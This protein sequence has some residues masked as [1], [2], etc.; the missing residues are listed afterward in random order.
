MKIEGD[1]NKGSILIADFHATRLAMR[2]QSMP[3]RRFDPA[4]WA[5][6]ALRSE[7]GQLML[8][9]SLE[10]LPGKAFTVGRLFLEPDPPG[11][12]VWV[13]ASGVSDRLIELVYQTR[14][15]SRVLRDEILPT[16]GDQ[17][18]DGS[19]HWSIF[20]LSCTLPTGWSLKSQRLNAGDLTLS[21][22]KRNAVV[23]VRQIA[24]A[25]LALAR[26]PLEKWLDAQQRLWK[27]LYRPD[28]EVE[29]ITPTHSHVG[30]PILAQALRRRRRFFLARWV[31]WKRF[32]LAAHD[33][34]RDRLVLVDA[35]SIEVAAQVLETVGKAG[36]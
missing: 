8:E 35:D 21:F 22:G 2:W 26:Q 14:T 31:A 9:K 34:R 7:V 19:L 28:G 27:K 32:T 29:S 3:K 11:R 30:G 5:R 16:L 33:T 24:P 13:G 17:R 15:R 10:H 18:R 6:N 23:V 20:D 1:W 36:A 25:A 4:D 12:D